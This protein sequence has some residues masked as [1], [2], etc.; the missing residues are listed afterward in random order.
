MKNIKKKTRYTFIQYFN[1]NLI[2]MNESILVNITYIDKTNKDFSRLLE[3]STS[4][5]ILL[6]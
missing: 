1:R 2:N 6:G 4:C 3:A 5:N